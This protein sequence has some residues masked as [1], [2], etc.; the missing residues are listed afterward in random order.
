[1]VPGVSITGGNPKSSAGISGLGIG[2]PGGYSLPS[3]HVTP[4][5]TAAPPSSRPA[6]APPANPA[7]AVA[8]KVKSG[9]TPEQIFG[10]RQFYTLHVNTPNTSSVSGSWILKFA[11]LEENRSHRNASFP[12]PEKSGELSGPVPLRKVDPRYP[13]AQRQA[14][15]QGEVVLYAIIRAN[16]TVDSIQV[17]RSLDSVLD[18][19]AMEALAEW[20][21]QPAT[22]NGVPVDLEAIV[23]IPFRSVA[24]NY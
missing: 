9:A 19:N 14:G 8:E 20:K 15:I 16:G 11:E 21:F 5:M 3:L 4:G 18:K 2:R 12:V 13:P 23:H 6:A 17:I 1:M 10:E 7:D 24:P 22:R